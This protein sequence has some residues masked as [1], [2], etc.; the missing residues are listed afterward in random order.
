M[1]IY[2]SKDIFRDECNAPLDI[3]DVSIINKILHGNRQQTPLRKH[4]KK[5]MPL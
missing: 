3:P 5:N 1:K 2:Y 4:K